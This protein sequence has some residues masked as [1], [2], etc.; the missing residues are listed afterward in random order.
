MSSGTRIFI[1][2]LFRPESEESAKRIANTYSCNEP[3]ILKR[4]FYISFLASF[5]L[6]EIEQQMH[7]IDLSELL[8]KVVSDYHLCVY[9]K[10]YSHIL[11]RIFYTHAFYKFS[12]R[13][14]VVQDSIAPRRAMHI[15]NSSRY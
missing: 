5:E 1:V 11:N 4:D 13:F 9:D 15:V 14:A 7:S 10:K 2:D 12:H 6:A 8:V 3:E